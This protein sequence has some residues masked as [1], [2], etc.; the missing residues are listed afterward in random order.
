MK[1]VAS[2]RSEF[3]AGLFVITLLAAGCGSSDAD[4]PSSTVKEEEVNVCSS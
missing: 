1:L 4:E 3:A 2:R